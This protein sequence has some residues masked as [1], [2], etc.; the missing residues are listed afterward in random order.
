MKWTSS[1]TLALTLVVGAP[2]VHADEANDMWS[3]LYGKLTALIRAGNKDPKLVVSLNVPGTPLPKDLKTDDPDDQD[4]IADLL[5]IAPKFNTQWT[6]SNLPI[7]TVFDN[8]V[9]NHALV[10]V[11]PLTSTEQATLDTYY[12]LTSGD[13]ADSYY[14]WKAK[15]AALKAQ[16]AEEFEDYQRKHKGK[17]PSDMD[18]L[19]SNSKL[20]KAQNNFDKPFATMV[21]VDG[22]DVHCGG[23][24]DF[25]ANQAKIADLLA[26]DPTNWWAGVKAKWDPIKAIGKFPIKTFPR[27]EQWVSDDGWV[28]FSYSKGEQADSSKLSEQDIKAQMSIKTGGFHMDANFAKN[29]KSAEVLNSASDL[30]ITLKVKRVFIRYPWFDPGVLSDKRYKMTNGKNPISR[31]VMNGKTI[32]SND[33]D[34]PMLPN[35]VIIVKDVTFK[36]SSIQKSDRKEE[37]SLSA[38]LSVGYGPFSC[39]GSYSKHNQKAEVKAKQVAG[40]ITIPE[41]QIIG[42]TSLANDMVPAQ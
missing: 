13:Y 2:A 3:Q 33:G 4:Y 25:E 10:G 6:P 39:S 36:S 32:L 8:I 12:K 34:L 24:K 5:N 18:M 29:D 11:T 14:D 23:S 28:E 16:V 31:P 41:P 26:K 7:S 40:S 9:N 22:E 20:T 30:T 42:Y 21:K 19:P 1:L 38:G 15:V 35:S 27:L 37:N 17:S